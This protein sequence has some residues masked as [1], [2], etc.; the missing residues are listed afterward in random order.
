MGFL[1]Y[2]SIL[3]FMTSFAVYGHLYPKFG[4]GTEIV[5]T[6]GGLFFPFTWFLYIG[7]YFDL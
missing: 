6:V 5:A 2:Y 7:S 1:K 4:K 3:G